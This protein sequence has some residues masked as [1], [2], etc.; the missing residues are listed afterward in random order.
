MLCAQWWDRPKEI[1]KLG[2]IPC[3]IFQTG[4]NSFASLS[5]VTIGVLAVMTLTQTSTGV[6]ELRQTFKIAYHTQLRI[7]AFVLSFLDLQ[8]RERNL[9]AREMTQLLVESGMGRLI[10]LPRNDS[11]V[12]AY[13]VAQ[14]GGIKQHINAVVSQNIAR[15]AFAQVNGLLNSEAVLNSHTEIV[16]RDVMQ[17]VHSIQ[18][19]P[20]V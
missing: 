1:L 14:S 16:T 12:G 15:D 6:E 20:Q 8:T 5:V 2:K 7:V 19:V 10:D 4:L 9:F 11:E 18:L 13:L 3:A 17:I